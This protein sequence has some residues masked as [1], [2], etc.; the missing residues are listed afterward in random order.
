MICLG[1]HGE[2]K[3]LL[4]NVNNKESIIT[5]WPQN[6]QNQIQDFFKTFSRLFHKIQDF[7][8]TFYQYYWHFIYIIDTFLHM[9]DTI[10]NIDVLV[11]LLK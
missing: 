4:K 11:Y 2:G 7:L 9:I 6:F 3:E 5:G 1:G 10:T 8:S